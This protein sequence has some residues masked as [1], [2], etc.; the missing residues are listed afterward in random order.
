MDA[1]LDET[2]FSPGDYAAAPDLQVFPV[3]AQAVVGV[4][5]LPKIPKLTLSAKI[6][7]N[8]YRAVD[9]PGSV[10]INNL[11]SPISN[12]IYQWNHSMLITANPLLDADLRE[13][14]ATYGSI[15]RFTR[16]DACGTNQVFRMG[17]GTAD[18]AAYVSLQFCYL[19]AMQSDWSNQTGSISLWR[20]LFVRA[21]QLLGQNSIPHSQQ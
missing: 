17:V 5:N 13:A 20:K 11:G 10:A 8:I 2:L 16:A 12:Q 9:K 21:K 18:P 6:L 1:I 4:Y 14:A 3:M 19:R 7:G 15:I